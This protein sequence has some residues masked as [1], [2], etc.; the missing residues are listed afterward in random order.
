VRGPLRLPTF[1][2]RPVEE[3]ADR[4]LNPPGTPAVDFSAPAGEPA[5]VPAASVSWQ[6]FKNPVTLF[7]GGVAAVLLEL[8]EPRVR[9][10]VWDHSIF[11]TKPLLRLQRTGLAALVTVYGAASQARAMI[12]GVTRMHARVS[13]VTPTG[14]VYHALDPQLLTW[15]HATASYGFLEAYARYARPLAPGDRDTYWEEGRPVAALFG[16]KASPGSERDWAE[17]LQDMRPRLGPSPIQSEFLGI[18]RQVSAL[19]A[20]ARPA[21]HLLIKAAVE[22]L[23]GGLPEQL[24]LGPE[25]RLR[26]WERRMVRTMARTADRLVIRTW[27]SV[28]AC[29]RLGLPDRHLYR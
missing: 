22:C 15:V 7:I 9:H 3:F 2:H 29:R 24:G 14:E 28:Q 6:V 10:G 19:P 20:Y 25:R 18:M 11:A 1:L 26:T 23:P 4:L 27:P 16:A 17:L 13:G 12:A 5:L 21:Q 8:A